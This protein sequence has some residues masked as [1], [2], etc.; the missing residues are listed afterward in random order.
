[1]PKITYFQRKRRD[2]ANYSIEQIFGALAIRFSKNYQVQQYILPFVSLGL[3]KRL[4][5]LLAATLNQGD[6][7]HVTGDINY[8]AILLKKEKT[9][10]TIH[11]LGILH[12][13]TGIRRKILLVIWFSLPVKRSK[14]VT[15]V[16][17]ATKDDLLKNVS[18]NPD[19]IKV[20]YVPISKDFKPKSKAFN[21]TKPL[22]LQIGG[23]PNKNLTGLIHA[24]KEIPCKL[25]IIGKIAPENQK[26]LQ[27]YQ[28]AF[29]NRVGISPQEVVQCYEQCD[30]LFFASTFEGFGMPILEAQ[31]VGRPVIT[32]NMLS[33][34]EVGGDAAIYVNPHNVQEIKDNICE[35]IANPQLRES[36]ISKGFENVKRFDEETIAQQYESLYKLVLKK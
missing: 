36:L 19:K 21:A 11:D 12:R 6:V 23:A 32:S 2:E 1:M 33:M 17:Q 15:V 26:L 22:I 8:A 28:I 13:T 25:L 5:N 18:C 9:I 35:L 34:P 16:S 29:E 31:A 20:I 24:V 14:W 27:E 10:S 30:L 4:F 3:F 7:N